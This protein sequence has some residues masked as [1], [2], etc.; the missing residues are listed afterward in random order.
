MLKQYNIGIYL[1]FV[2]LY[3]FPAYIPLI[4]SDPIKRATFRPWKT[5]SFMKRSNIKFYIQIYIFCDYKKDIECMLHK[6]Q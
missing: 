4:K 2:T 6:T 5:D 1:V 3:L